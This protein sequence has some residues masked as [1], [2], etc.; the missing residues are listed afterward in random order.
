MYQ[1]LNISS[2]KGKSI[3]LEDYPL[4]ESGSINMN[5]I[6]E[7]DTLIEVISLGRAARNKANIKIRQPLKEVVIYSQDMSH[8]EYLMTN[9]NDILE[10]LNIKNVRFANKAEELVST[11]IKPDFQ[12]LGQKFNKNMKEVLS[13]IKQ[14][15]EAILKDIVLTRKIKY[16]IS[17][18][19]EVDYSDFII[20][21]IP[22]EGFEVSSNNS[23]IVAIN[24]NIDDSLKK[25]G[26]VRDL[27]RH[28]QNFRKESGLDISDRISISI[29]PSEDL[30]LAIKNHKKYF[31][32]EVLGVNIRLDGHDLDFNKDIQIGSHKIRLGL[33]KEN[34]E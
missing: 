21:E 26:M 1:N 27:I 12:V 15:D 34:E 23:F 10:E 24:I 9:E 7:V 4:S 19:I 31:M 11:N 18:D 8:K 5:L 33:S 16:Q 17:K 28:V 32:N 20:E 30:V 3:H 14:L 2:S 6:Q 13:E 22:N 29:S 25:E